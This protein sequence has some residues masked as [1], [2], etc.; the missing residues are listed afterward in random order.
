MLRLRLFHTSPPL[1]YS[2]GVWLSPQCC[3]LSVKMLNFTV[4]LFVLIRNICCHLFLE[5]FGLSTVQLFSA[6]TLTCSFLFRCFVFPVCRCLFQTVRRTSVG[7]HTHTTYIGLYTHSSGCLEFYRR[8]TDGA[9]CVHTHVHTH[10]QTYTHI[11]LFGFLYHRVPG[12]RGK[13]ECQ[14]P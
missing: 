1:K 4:Y 5:E 11:P 8:Q 2:T 13:T 7:S 12:D 9:K 6:Y 3:L 10:R 14:E